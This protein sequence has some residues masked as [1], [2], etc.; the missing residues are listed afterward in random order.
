MIAGNAY[1][2]EEIATHCNA[3]IIGH[4]RHI[5]INTIAYDSRSFMPAGTSLFFCLK[6]PSNNGHRYI[7]SA[8]EK[9]VRH[10]VI[11]ENI[12]TES[13]PDA[14]FL[15]VADTLQALHDLAAAHR[16]KFTIPLVAITGSNGKTIVKEWLYQLLHTDKNVVRSPKSYNSQVGVPLSVWQMHAAHTLGIFEAGISLPGEMQAL[17]KILKPD[18]CIVTNIKKAHSENF[19]DKQ[20]IANEKLILAAHCKT[21]IYCSDYQEIENALEHLHIHVPEKLAWHNLQQHVIENGS[22]ISFCC[23]QQTY[24]FTLP[25][26]DA[27]AAE[28][29]VHCFVYLLHAGYSP[30]EIAQG[31]LSLQ[32]VEMRL[33][34][35]QGIHQ[36]TLINDAYNS[37]IASLEIAL[38]LL[39]AQA[40]G[41]KKILI[42]SDIIQSGLPPEKL[43]KEI[44]S[45]VKK[46]NIDVFIGIGEEISKYPSLFQAGTRL[47]VKTEDFLEVFTPSDFQQGVVLLKGARKYGF[48]QIAEKLLEKK[49]ETVLE[50]N[51]NALLQNYHFFRSRIPEKTRIMAMVKASSYGSGIAE[52]ARLLQ[53]H[54]TDYLAVAFADEGVAL[55]K[56][57]IHLPMLVMSPE[58]AAFDDMLTWNLEPEI[59]SIRILQAWLQAVQKKALA[60]A[61]PI[62][63][64]IDTGMHRLGFTENML[65]ELLQMLQ[66]H[67]EHIQVASVFSHLAASEDAAKDEF[68]RQQLKRFDAACF[69]LNQHLPYPF[70][71]HILNSNGILRFP[72]ACYEMVR[73]GIGLYGFV[74]KKQ[75]G[76]QAVSVLKTSISQLKTIQPGDTVG[77]GQAYTASENIRIAT[78]PI[79]Y[80]DGLSRRL[81]N[82]Q[83]QVKIG[84]QKAPLIGNICMDMCMADVTH[85][86]CAEGDEA[87]LFDAE[88]SAAEMAKAAGTITYEVLTGISNRV[89]RVYVYL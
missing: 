16:E 84:N 25:Y 3:H 32:A 43:Y 35:K 88:H 39:S 34:V 22:R 20:A 33:E 45:L 77:Y 89:K 15:Q 13:F 48:E 87:I 73:L 37:D 29:A 30:E 47:F 4:S 36:C 26:T 6:T 62:H 44:A 21:L 61:V 76:L 58:P 49:H 74:D 53:H 68:T 75:S 78:L 85:I 63:L 14:Y 86:D 19:T 60:Q 54:H 31:M 11:S 69:L 8:Y 10:F 80:A 42:L 65:P 40:A 24:Q 9:G 41:R 66:A 1:H 50:I 12:N 51:L 82:G 2:I 55:R 71:R 64:K 5:L 23:H 83:W 59:Y 28:N 27:A 67:A 18:V 72:D 52:V 70:L 46:N 7:A 56:A 81:G 17:E 38:N 57:G 79:G